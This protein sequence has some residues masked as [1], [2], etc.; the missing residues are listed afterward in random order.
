MLGH[1]FPDVE[2][3]VGDVGS[4]LS[5]ENPP[6]SKIAQI[7]DQGFEDYVLIGA[8]GSRKEGKAIYAKK[9]YGVDIFTR[10]FGSEMNAANYGSNLTTE[11]KSIKDVSINLLVVEDGDPKARRYRTGDCHGK[12][13]HDFAMRIA[14]TINNPFQFRAF[15]RQPAWCAKGTIAVGF[16]SGKYDLVLPT[17]SFKGNKVKPGEYNNISLAF[18][19]IFTSPFKDLESEESEESQEMTDYR[20]SN[21]SYSVLQFLPWEAV[22]KDV[23]PTTIRNCVSLNS[24]AGN[25][26]R[27]LEYLLREDANNPDDVQDGSKI[28]SILKADHYGQLST[29][30]WVVKATSQILGRRWRQVATSGGI[31]FHSS[32]VMPDED[33][34]DDH[35]YI[36]G[37]PDGEEV[38]VFPYPCRWKYD[39][40]VWR[41]KL[42]PRWEK[43]QGVI[44][45][46]CNTLLKLGRDTDGDF[47]MWLP[48]S[49][50]PN[51]AR[52][53]KA[54]GEPADQAGLKPKKVPITGTLGQ[55][56]V[57]SM[58]NLTGLITYYIAKSHACQQEDF[59]MQLVPQLQAAVDSLKGATPPDINLIKSIGSQLKSESVDWLKQ[60]KEQNCYVYYPMTQRSS[61]TI[62]M[63]IGE[64]NKF[65]IKPE[66]LATNLRSFQ[67][68]FSHYNPPE[69]W[70]ER[71][72]KV[73]SEYSQAMH[74]AGREIRDW[75]QSHRSKK[76]PRI[77]EERASTMRRSIMSYY[78]GILSHLPEEQRVIAVSAFW[79]ARHKSNDSGIPDPT[80]QDK[81]KRKGYSTHICFLVGL[82][83]ICNELQSLRLNKLPLVGRQYSD[84][85]DTIFQGELTV[86]K[87]VSTTDDKGN[88]SFVAKSEDGKS[89]GLVGIKSCPPIN[90][91]KESVKAYLHTRFDKAGNPSFTEAVIVE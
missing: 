24:L 26:R 11:C 63:L 31:T 36:P 5:Q 3:A 70:I 35:I 21:L 51:I 8:S 69:K 66:I 27:L 9:K 14:G 72:E 17:S 77:V 6:L 54:F 90:L 10:F 23:L 48:A 16:K 62:G 41:N 32:M 38:I 75:L 29:H 19:L 59:V 91:D 60:V 50:L 79:L 37:L 18:G 1:L 13:S 80:S 67:P 64:V 7:L 76:I 28:A 68:I 20:V 4:L 57:K 15:S 25:P 39:I 2:F 85:K 73:A 45:G 30:P 61:D 74:E 83:M 88:H 49:R 78:E 33:L 43:M 22:E 52:E 44:V 46:N 47:L 71:A 81:E 89:I 84:F 86:L 40:K 12:C 87:I 53:V 82:D 34:A 56:I 55:I 42:L 65:W 58:S